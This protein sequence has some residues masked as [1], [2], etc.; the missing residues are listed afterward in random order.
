MNATLN[1]NHSFQVDLQHISGVGTGV[2]VEN[3]MSMKEFVKSQEWDIMAIPANKTEIFYPCCA[4]PYP[5]ITF[6]ITMRRKVIFYAINT[7]I[8]CFGISMLACLT[9]YLPSD[10]G[11]KMSLCMSVLLSLSIFQWMMMEVVPATSWVT[12]L[13]GKFLT[14]T[15]LQVSL[16]ISI[17]VAALNMR[18]RSS[19]THDMPNW[20]RKV[21]L[22]KLPRLL[23]M[24]KPNEDDDPIS[25]G[26]GIDFL[27]IVSKW[28]DPT[29][30]DLNDYYRK[31]STVSSTFIGAP[32]Y[33]KDIDLSTLCEACARHKHN[34]MPLQVQKALEGATF[35]E[36]HHRD[37]TDSNLVWIDSFLFIKYNRCHW[38]QVMFLG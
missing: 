11:E 30:Y 37:E 18:Y 38:R 32:S 1:I 7:I 12:P 20:V 5:D 19:S 15:V 17:S 26:H 31:D 27:D 4:E 9:F 35:V 28:I 3:G 2:V 33:L 8:P 36:T 14:F 13:M 21:F 23:W 25:R 24:N 16:S 22:D 29:D 10:C 6:Y 34:S